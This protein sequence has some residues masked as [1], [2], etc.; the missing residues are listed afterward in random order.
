MSDL[1]EAIAASKKY[2]AAL[3]QKFKATG[4]GLH[5]KTTSI[6]GSLNNATKRHLR[7]IATVRNKL[8]HEDG[9]T[10]IAN[11]RQFE[12][13]CRYLDAYL[14][15]PAPQ[16][17][18]LDESTL[19]NTQ[20]AGSKYRS[21]GEVFMENRRREAWP[22]N[23]RNIPR[24]VNRIF[25]YNIKMKFF[26]TV[27]VC[28]LLYF[29]LIAA[30]I[31]L[32]DQPVDLGPF[33]IGLFIGFLFMSAQV[34]SIHISYRKARENVIEVWAEHGY[35]RE[36]FPPSEEICERLGIDREEFL[37]SPDT[38]V[39]RGKHITFESEDTGLLYRIKY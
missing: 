10:V 20:L 19:R 26:T 31:A 30:L 1:E 5:E 9:V 37:N 23:P 33:T 7:L 6:E 8:V 21:R 11:R 35:M 12:D 34:L 39:L 2:E 29:G 13:A 15:S 3:E 32:P 27:Y 24:S 16:E 18:E 36:G 28:L 22:P 17:D 25:F 14:V 4:K 38:V